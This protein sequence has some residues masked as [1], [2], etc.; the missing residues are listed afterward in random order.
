M[1]RRVRDLLRSAV[2]DDDAR[3]ALAR[4]AL[5]EELEAVGF[6]SFAGIA[7]APSKKRT[8]KSSGPTRRSNRNSDDA[9]GSTLSARS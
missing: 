3:D 8:E 5:T 1:R 4:G 6:S 9:S 2:A 7:P